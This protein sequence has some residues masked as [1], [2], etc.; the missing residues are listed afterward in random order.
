MSTAD[1]LGILPLAILA[2]GALV[3]LFE[4]NVVRSIDI[5]TA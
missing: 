5:Q 2:G 1:F 3:V 4:R